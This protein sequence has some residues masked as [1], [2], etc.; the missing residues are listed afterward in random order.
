MSDFIL[1]ISEPKFYGIVV[2]GLDDPNSRIIAIRGSEGALEW[3]DDAAAI[4][5]PFRRARCVGFRQNL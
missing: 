1:D 5:V 2:H 4:L 3:M